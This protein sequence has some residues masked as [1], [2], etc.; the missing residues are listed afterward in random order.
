MQLT[1]AEGRGEVLA[2]YLGSL[3][4]H[5]SL[6]GAASPG[7]S[8]PFPPPGGGEGRFSIRSFSY[9]FGGEKNWQALRI[10]QIVSTLLPSVDALGRN[11]RI[12]P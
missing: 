2:L 4:A 3:T 8:P 11:P 12:A 1:A 7:H 6:R 9:Y 10:L 5:A